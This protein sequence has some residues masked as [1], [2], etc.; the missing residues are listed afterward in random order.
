MSAFDVDLFV[1][2]AGSGGVRAARIAAGY[3]AKVLVA[4]E[5]RV[6]GTCVIRGCIPKKLMVYASRFADDF[7]DAAGFGWTL[8]KP[9][10][11]WNKLV[12]AKEMEISRLSAIYRTNLDKAGV[13]IID[14]RAE[15]EGPHKIRLKSNGQEI[16]ARYILVS[17]GGTPVLE[18]RIPGLEYTITSNE[19]FDLPNLPNHMLIVGGGYI[20]VEFAS[21]FTR[22]GTKITLVVRSENVLRGFDEDMRCS[23][24]DA[25]IQ[26]GVD[27]KT[28]TLPTKIEKAASGFNVTLTDGTVLDVDHV[29]LAT[30]RHPHTKGLGLEKAGVELDALG[31]VK[32]DHFSKTNVD[33]IY[34]VGDVTNRIA[35]TPVAIREGHAFA[36]TVFGNK[37]TMVDYAN[38]ATA[39]FTTPELGTVG[40]T[41]EQA[42]EQ[43]DCVD[44]YA[45]SFRPLKATLS[46]R[47]EKTSMKIVVDGTT[48]RVLGVHIFGDD[49]GEMAQIL[50]IAVKL[51]VKKADFDATMAVHP[52]SAEELVTMRVRTAR[53][54]RETIGEEG[55]NAAVAGE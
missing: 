13:S 25:L 45:A 52:T 41:E 42:R 46:G 5:F 3:G 9:T 34:A 29:M 27:L 31:A 30:G 26:E 40:L 37:E 49:A 43:F 53:Y 19:V 1:I 8:V 48:D 50:G 55:P 14:S 39:V 54:E 16:S 28:V 2:G 44:V 20:A 38:I 36:D 18:P 6:G 17:T 32:V 22:L 51:G 7:A 4:E 21:V 24:R 33:S 11:D 10:F 47:Q 12:A 35:L 15:V 23:V